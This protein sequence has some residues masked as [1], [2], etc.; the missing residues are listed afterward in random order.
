MGR[1]LESIE[2]SNPNGGEMI[3]SQPI[4]RGKAFI[5]L[6]WS[7][8]CLAYPSLR[9]GERSRSDGYQRMNRG[10]GGVCI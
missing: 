5:D 9:P 10:V 1:E 8:R 3:P 6:D 4:R 2:G 7:M